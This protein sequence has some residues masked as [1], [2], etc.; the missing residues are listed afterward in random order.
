MR[1]K[2]LPQFEKFL[3]TRIPSRE[4]L[5]MGDTGIKRTKYFMRLLGDPQDKMKVIHIAGTSGKGSTAYLMSHLLQSQ[6]FKV[7]LSVSPHIFNIR[8]RIQIDNE[9]PAE[10]LILKYFNEILPIISQME[11]HR[12]GAPTY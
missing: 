5:F 10:K 2:T 9:L 3:K 7:G 4:A 8:E 11:K 6:G 12:Y 1:I